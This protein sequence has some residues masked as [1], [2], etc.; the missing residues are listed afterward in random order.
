VRFTITWRNG[1]AGIYTGTIDDDGFMT[2]RSRDKLSGATASFDFAPT[3]E[4]ARYS[5]GRFI[6]RLVPRGGSQT[7]PVAVK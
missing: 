3:I 2:G 5:S 4:C 1:S 6:K 7:P